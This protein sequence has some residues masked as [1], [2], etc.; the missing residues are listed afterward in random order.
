MVVKDSYSCARA[1]KKSTSISSSAPSKK[2]TKKAI[3]AF[4]K[5]PILIVAVLFFIIGVAGGFF[6]FKALSPFELNNYLVN[7][8]IS[9]ETDYVIIDISAIKEEFLATKADATM[10]EIYA[11]I[12]LK[13]ELVT[14]KFFGA[15]IGDTIS[16]KYYY[17]EDI[18]HNT[19]EVTG[20]DVQTAGVYYIEYTSNHFA[21]KNTTLIRTIIVTE[22]ENDG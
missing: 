1:T 8:K 14:C 12:N 19:K 11:S 10:E 7:G 22:V 3:N 20:I 16:T 5:S 2:S 18:S 6:A 17:R 4:K 15:D 9:A 13:D 21:H